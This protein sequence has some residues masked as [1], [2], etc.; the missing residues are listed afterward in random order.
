MFQEV[1]EEIY[2]NLLCIIL[3]VCV[4]DDFL[5]ATKLFAKA[6]PRITTCLS[7]RNNLAEKLV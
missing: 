2:L 3:E 6:L 7:A 4:F 1:Y 5:S